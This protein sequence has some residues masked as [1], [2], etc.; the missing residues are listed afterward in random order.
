MFL[1]LVGMFDRGVPSPLSRPRLSYALL[2]Y[3]AWYRLPAHGNPRAALEEANIGYL[4]CIYARRSD[5]YEL[6]AFFSTVIVLEHHGWYDLVCEHVHLDGD[7][8]SAMSAAPL[9]GRLHH[10]W[11]CVD[12]CG[13]VA[14]CAGT[15][16]E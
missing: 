3:H 13:H 14:A 11:T 5:K 7:H 6:R 9:T 12:T 4:R 2:F 15:V 10:R 16:P 8:A 1:V